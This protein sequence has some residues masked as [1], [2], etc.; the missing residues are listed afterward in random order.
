MPNFKVW[1]KEKKPREKKK[2]TLELKPSPVNESTKQKLM[3]KKKN[4]RLIIN[5][6]QT[7]T[8]TDALIISEK[9]ELRYQGQCRISGIS[10]KLRR[11]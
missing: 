6:V 4:S 2:V 10:G 8:N 5:M 11:S 9:A 7:Q 1:Q 3:N